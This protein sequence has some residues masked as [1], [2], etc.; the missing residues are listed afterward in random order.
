MAITAMVA[1]CND[2]EPALVRGDRFWA[3]SNFSDA[4]AEYRL[5]MGQQPTPQNKARVAHAYIETGQFERAREIYDELIAQRSDYADQAIFDYVR[6]ARRAAARSDRYSMA[7]AVDAATRLRPGLPLDDLALPLARYYASTGDPP[8][9]LDFYERALSVAPADSVPALLF[10]IAQM[11]ESQGNCAEATGFFRAFLSR[12]RRHP[13]TGEAQWHIGNCAWTLGRRAQQDGNQIRALDY[14]NT[15]IALGVPENLVDDA[16][17]ERGE[18]LIQLGN[19]DEAMSAFLRV[20]E[21]NRTGNNQLVDRARR[22][23]D[24]LRFGRGVLF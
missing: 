18:I 23:I 4:L 17:F 12:T 2:A 19:R 16:W 13:R 11:H 1:A 24:Q 8:R 21:L 22:R 6:V 10:E 20:L 14:L 7:S 9:A 15:V 3:D 5:A